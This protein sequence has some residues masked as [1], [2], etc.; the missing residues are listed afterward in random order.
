MRACPSW[1]NDWSRLL[2]RYSTRS[3]GAP[4]HEDLRAMVEALITAYEQSHE[5]DAAIRFLLYSG[6]EGP[7]EQQIAEALQECHARQQ[8]S[9]PRSRAGDRTRF[10]FPFPFGLA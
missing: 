4:D 6:A 5:E 2:G 1:H 7:R 10:P 8:H 3:Q 9:S